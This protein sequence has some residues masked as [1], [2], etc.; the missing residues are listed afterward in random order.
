MIGFDPVML[1]CGHR[2]LVDRRPAVSMVGCA[3]EI[4]DV[5]AGRM[6]GRHAM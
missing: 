5:G 6:T 2:E 3:D 4:G 1:A